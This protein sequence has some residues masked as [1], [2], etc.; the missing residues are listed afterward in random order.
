MVVEKRASGD[1]DYRREESDGSDGVDVFDEEN[2]H[3]SEADFD[4]LLA[5][6]EARQGEGREQLGGRTQSGADAVVPVAAGARPVG[7]QRDSAVRDRDLGGA[8]DVPADPD[9][10]QTGARTYH[11]AGR[12]TDGHREQRATTTGTFTAAA[13]AAGGGA[14]TAGALDDGEGACGQRADGAAEAT[15]GA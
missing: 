7:C 13:A 4:Y 15:E 11:C 8:A 1:F 5:E 6:D 14:A 9:R 2:D 10:R 12:Y 3:G